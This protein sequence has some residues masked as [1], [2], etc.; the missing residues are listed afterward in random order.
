MTKTLFPGELRIG[1]KSRFPDTACQ[2]F[3]LIPHPTKYGLPAHSYYRADSDK[4]YPN[5][6]EYPVS[7][8]AEMSNLLVLN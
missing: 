3:D 6:G 2:S 8:Y 7:T 5:V 4:T 1:H